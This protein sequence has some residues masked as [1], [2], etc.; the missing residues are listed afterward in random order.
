MHDM[1]DASENSYQNRTNRI[2]RYVH[3]NLTFENMPPPRCLLELDERKYLHL[4]YIEMFWSLT[5]FFGIFACNMQWKCANPL[6]TP[7]AL[8]M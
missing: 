4:H 8:G 2:N 1:I 5:L 3:E 7:T 6:N